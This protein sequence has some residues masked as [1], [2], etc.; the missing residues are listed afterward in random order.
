MRFYS[1]RDYQTFLR[2]NKEVVN[3]LVDTTVVLYKM[4]TDM[5]ATNSYGEATK[6]VWYKGVQV[7]CLID[8]D[9]QNPQSDMETI[10]FEQTVKFAFL[11]DELRTRQ[12]YP[13]A[14]DIVDFDGQYYEI[15]NTNENQLI[16][17]RVEYNHSIVAE[18]HLTRKT[19]LQLDKPPV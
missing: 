1:D 15:D 6:K 2:M 14:G 7:P 8:R 10:N 4:K 16:A 13:E 3:Q 5:T 17:G 19:N 9:Q 18:C 11:K 12:I